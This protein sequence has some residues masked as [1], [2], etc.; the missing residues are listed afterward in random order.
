M[1]D[2]MVASTVIYPHPRGTRLANTNARVAWVLLRTEQVPRIFEPLYTT[3]RMLDSR[4]VLR[5]YWGNSLLLQAFHQGRARGIVWHK[6][7][8][9]QALTFLLGGLRPRNPL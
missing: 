6:V 7:R 4:G 9:Y 3:R 5:Q 1:V 8:C 2:T